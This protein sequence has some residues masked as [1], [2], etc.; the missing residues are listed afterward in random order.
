VPTECYFLD[1][2][3]VL[4]DT[5]GIGTVP[6]FGVGFTASSIAAAGTYSLTL[7]TVQGFGFH[8]GQTL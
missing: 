8:R 6:N 5:S 3:P 2:R 1:I 7:A 4:H